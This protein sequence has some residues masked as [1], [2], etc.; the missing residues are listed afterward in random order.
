MTDEKSRERR[1]FLAGILS[2]GA[3]AIPLTSAAS[4][5]SLMG[6]FFAERPDVLLAQV[7]QNRESARVVGRAYLA[8]IS[9]KPG[10]A[11]LEQAILS[12]VGIEVPEMQ[13]MDHEKLHERLRTRVQH[14]FHEHRTVKVNGWVLSVT[15]ARLAA[16][17]A[18]I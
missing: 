9:P 6:G 5:K 14:D 3:A 4:Q 1:A 12:S 8:G 11:E 7:L 13:S 2:M 16:L 10:A 18:T 17:V 15:E